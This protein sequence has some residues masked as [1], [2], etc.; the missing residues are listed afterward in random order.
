MD[1]VAD[2][3]GIVV[4]DLERSKAFYRALGF[5]GGDERVMADKTLSF[6]HLGD[7][8]IELFEYDE[9]AAAAERPDRAL[10]FKH[11]ALTTHDIDAV[12]EELR[13]G[14]CHRRGHRHSRDV[15]RVAPAVLPRPGRHGDRDQAGVNRLA[16]H[17]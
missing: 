5:T 16:G 13:R 9:P 15:Q 1:L 7:L 8:A 11:L 6:M 2:H 10:G 14:G 4:S 17:G 12:Y 3:V